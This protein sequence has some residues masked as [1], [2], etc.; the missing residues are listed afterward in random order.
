MSLTDKIQ[1]LCYTLY[2]NRQPVINRAVYVHNQLHRIM[3][4]V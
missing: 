4:L 2:V 3:P 1:M